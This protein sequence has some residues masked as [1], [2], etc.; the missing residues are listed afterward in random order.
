ML[1]KPF[2]G[3]DVLFE[4]PGAAEGAQAARNRARVVLFRALVHELVLRQVRFQFESLVA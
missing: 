1:R 3:V 2:V 4:V